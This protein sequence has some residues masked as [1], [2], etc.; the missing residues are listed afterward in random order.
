MGLFSRKKDGAARRRLKIL[1]VTDLHGS[2]LTFR[3][4]LNSL[5][6][7]GP[8]VLV[9]GGDV[10]GK[11]LL[12][13][14][15]NGDGSVRV[16]FMGEERDMDRDQLDEV[17]AKAGQLGFYPH[18]ADADE[19]ERL[20][21]DPDAYEQIF[22]RLMRERW[23]DWLARLEQRCERLELPAFAI[24]GNDDPWSLDAITFEEREWVQGADGK[25]LDLVG[26][27]KLLSCGLANQTPWGCPRDLPEDELG[28]KLEELAAQ[29]GDFT[30]VVA[31]IHVPPYN[32]ALDIAP[33]L[34][35]SVTPP[36][37][38]AGSTVPVGS[39]AVAEF[40][41]RHQPLLSLHGHIHES[42][43]AVTIGRTQAIN[44]GSEYA[45]GILRGVLVTIERDRVVGHQF[46]TG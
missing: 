17:Y 9:C 7:W 23:S 29:V 6:I 12:P 45:E 13:V 40:I 30:N 4:F 26:D 20:N 39:T 44:P 1:F 21:A 15:D 33:E 25:V 27:W 2:E 18:L 3:K 42:P 36:R 46:V 37:A 35:T 10:A 11:G 34:D 19:L 14:L 38:I 28:A 5:E 32:S 41:G 8:D 16:R 24:A 43:G 22:E 31:N